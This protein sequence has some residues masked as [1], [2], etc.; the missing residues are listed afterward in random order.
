M[1]I[2]E[3]E[4]FLIES[5]RCDGPDRPRSLLVRMRT[6]SGLEGWGE[7]A[8][9]WRPDELA[10]RRDS[11]LA[12]L[13]GRSV[14]DIEELHLLDA[15]WPPPIRAAVEMAAWDLLG[16]VLRQPLCNLLGGFY[17]RR[18]PVSVRLEGCGCETAANESREL[19]EQ[20]FHTIT[21]AGSGIPDDDAAAVKAIRELLGD[22]ITLRLDGQGLYDFEVARDICAELEYEGLQYFL[23]PIKTAEIH[24]SAVLGRQTNVPLA[25]WRSIRAG[26]DVFAAARCGAAP[27]VVIDLEQLGGIAPAKACAAV[28]C[29][30]GIIPVLGCRASSGVSTAAMLHLAASTPAI[31]IANEIA[32]C[33]LRDSVLADSPEIVEG[34]ILVPESPGL[35]V[36]V[37]RSKLERR[38]PIV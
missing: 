29:A 20:G 14:F 33:Q 5:D 24:P 2:H 9:V 34:M 23:D 8:F 7:S 11:L 36:E 25:L 12:A 13:S 4:L 32:P 17:R 37:D 10:A 16:R 28:A 38:R 6:A 22:R 19:A 3:L 1:K 27:F 21:V 18:I 31:S 30:A 26:G 35:G 15:L